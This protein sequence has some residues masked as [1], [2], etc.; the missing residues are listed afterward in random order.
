MLGEPGANNGNGLRPEGRVRFALNH[1]VQPQLPLP[2][3]FELAR[4]VGCDAVEIRNDIAGQAILDGT[5]AAEVRSLAVDAGVEILTINALQRFNDWSATREREAAAL[6]AYAR[7]CGAGAIILVPTNDG[8]SISGERLRDALRRLEPILADAGIV[9]LVEPLGFA[10]CS[11]RSKAEAVASIADVG[12]AR[13]FRLVHDTFHHHLAGEPQLFPHSTGLVHVS[14]VTDPA[15]SVADMR[16]AHRVL[17]DARDRIGN[18][19]QIGALVAGGYGGPVS[20]EPFS[21]E[22]RHLP[23]PAAAVRASMQAITGWAR[24]TALAEKLGV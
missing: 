15:L 22:M 12:G 16:D 13:T 4:Q 24:R 14:G 9:G 1:M 8:V 11:L 19:E 6:A 7:D 2:A 23:D 10:A 17:V 21:E 20:F 3:F 18:V 5:P